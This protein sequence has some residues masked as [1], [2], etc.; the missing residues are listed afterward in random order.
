VPNTFITPTL[1][2]KPAL[3]TWW[4]SSV[5]VGL[6][7]RA[8]TSDFGGGRGDTVTIKRQPT[9]TSSIFNRTNG[10]QVQ[11]VVES[12]ITVQVQD[13]YDVSV[14]IT[15]EQMD[16]SLE[17]FSFAVAEPAGQALSRQAEALI[18]AEMAA[19][20]LPGAI[21]PLDPVQSLI[22][23]RQALNASEVPLEGRFLAVG[24]D[25]AA[26]LLGNDRFLKANENGSDQAL[27]SANIGQILGMQVYESVVLPAKE[28]FVCHPDALTFVSIVPQVMRGT[29]D[30]ASASYDGLGMRTVFTYDQ[31]RK[32]D[33]VS[34][35]SYY[36]V[37]P[38]RGDDGFKR[39]ALP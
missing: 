19:Q 18:A 32:T 38:L 3:A 35:D 12:S 5:L 28:A 29:P 2:S 11:D 24:T 20:A 1:I 31:N 26:N 21:D 22:T 16:F 39:L 25:V 4:N 30:G 9:L 36:Q 33:L 23:A 17:D 27:R 8:Y 15:Q 34:F 10:V 13:L 6:F 7:N 14:E 37:A